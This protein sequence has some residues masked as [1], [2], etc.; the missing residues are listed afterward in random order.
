MSCHISLHSARGGWR[1]ADVKCRVLSGGVPPQPLHRVQLMQPVWLCISQ[2]TS[3]TALLLDIFAYHSLH[4]LLPCHLISV[5]I[6]AYITYCL[7]TWYL[8]ILQPTSLLICLVTVNNIYC[9]VTLHTYPCIT[10]L[11]HLLPCYLI[12]LHITAYITYCLV[13]WYLCILQPT[14]LTALSLDNFAYYSLHHFLPVL[15]QSITFTVLLLL[16]LLIE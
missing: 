12:T 11:H 16:L 9:L 5:H 7:V 1:A 13:T 15:L 8:C 10:S 6:T 4:H 14:S 2:P 3:L